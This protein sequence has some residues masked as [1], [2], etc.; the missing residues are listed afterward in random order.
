M[1]LTFCKSYMKT[2]RKLDGFL[3]ESKVTNY[4]MRK[5][6]EW[7]LSNIQGVI[8]IMILVNIIQ[9]LSVPVNPM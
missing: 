2:D 1:L 9:H 5:L 7:V 4:N 8:S 6:V 3:G